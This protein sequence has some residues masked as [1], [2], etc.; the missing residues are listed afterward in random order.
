MVQKKFQEN[1]QD[2]GSFCPIRRIEVAM[3]S[4]LEI[5]RTMQLSGAVFLEAEFT[6]P[7]CITSRIAPED[8]IPFMPRPAQVI[9]YHYVT[10]GQLLLKVEGYSPTTI[11]AGEIILLPR[12]DEH[13]LASAENIQ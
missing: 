7:W 6:A 12:N 4:L 2:A 8:C 13:V 9:S 3:D 10:A 5:C 11:K 1:D